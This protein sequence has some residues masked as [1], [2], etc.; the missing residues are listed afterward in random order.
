M[1]HSIVHTCS[2]KVHFQ[3]HWI[4]SPLTFISKT[5]S[6]TVTP[7][8]NYH[9]EGKADREKLT[10]GELES[11]K[12]L[13]KGKI[14]QQTLPQTHPRPY[15]TWLQDLQ[16]V[17]PRQRIPGRLQW[18]SSAHLTLLGP[19]VPPCQLQ[20]AKGKIWQKICS[21]AL[22]KLQTES[23]P[24]KRKCEQSSKGKG[25]AGDQPSVP[26]GSPWKVPGVAEWVGHNSGKALF[27]VKSYKK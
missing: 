17:T 27:R 6:T 11:Q 22:W 8:E 2:V 13:S 3:W 12:Q 24:E 16:G 23:E 14:W 19:S 26:E 9:K 4:N 10:T 5:A 1:G 21:E 15:P 7:L 25:A 20:L 18:R